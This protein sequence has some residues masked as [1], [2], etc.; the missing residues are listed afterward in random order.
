[1]QKEYT[2]CGQE[3]E[4]RGEEGVCGRQSGNKHLGVDHDEYLRGLD[5]ERSTHFRGGEREKRRKEARISWGRLN[6]KRKD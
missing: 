5:E 1:M 2:Y 3:N 4:G 6:F